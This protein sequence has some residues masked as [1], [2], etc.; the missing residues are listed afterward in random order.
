MRGAISLEGEG[1]KR[2]KEEEER[3]EEEKEEEQT[4]GLNGKFFCEIFGENESE[5]AGSFG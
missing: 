2:E 4:A 5:V 3:E 1:L